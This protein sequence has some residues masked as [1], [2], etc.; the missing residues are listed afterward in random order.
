MQPAMPVIDDIRAAIM[1][2]CDRQGITQRQL[3]ELSGIHYVT[4]SRF[5]NSHLEPSIA[6]CEKLA[7][8]ANLRLKILLEKPTQKKIRK[9]G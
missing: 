4:I 5:F 3:A 7:Q 9:I 6:V 8:A 1:A 2:A